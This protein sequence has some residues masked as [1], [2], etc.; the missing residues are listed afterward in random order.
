MKLNIAYPRNGTVKSF[1]IAD[2]VIRRGNV[3]ENRLGNDVEGH[4]FGPQFEG[5][6]FRLTGGSDKQGF[7][8]VQGVL[9]ASRVSLLLARGATGFNT[10]RGRSGERRRKAIRG[11]ILGPD[12]GNLNVTVQKVGKA[13]V[14]GVT[15]VV[16]PR[17]LGP[18]RASKI[19]K[20]FDLGA[21]DDV[22]RFVV[23]R[24]VEKPGKKIRFKAPRIQRLLTPKVRAQRVRKVHAHR[25]QLKKSQAQRREYL[26]LITTRR[27][28]HRQQKAAAGHRLSVAASKMF[29]KRSAPTTAK[30]TTSKK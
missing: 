21:G 16:V 1:E 18:K 9:A 26:S 20:L 28:K 19:R 8:M 6:V 2:D 10:F 29:A 5:Y 7:P 23:R 30:K 12:I 14:E 24:K 27:M 25:D 4:V 3:Y 13:P 11:C 15:D 22:R 17:R